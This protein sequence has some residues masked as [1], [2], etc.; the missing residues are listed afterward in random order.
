MIASELA[1]LTVNRFDPVGRVD[2]LATRSGIPSR[3][4]HARAKQSRGQK[5]HASNETATHCRASAAKQ[6]S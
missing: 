2:R 4:R 1:N 5:P 6:I 3:L